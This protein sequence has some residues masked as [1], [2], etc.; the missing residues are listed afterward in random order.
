MD[1]NEH[2]VAKEWA[3]PAFHVWS[4]PEGSVS[5]WMWILISVFSSG[6]QNI[7]L[8]G[9][10]WS[11]PHGP[12]DFDLGCASGWDTW[13]CLGLIFCPLGTLLLPEYHSGELSEKWGTHQ[14]FGNDG[15][16]CDVGLGGKLVCGLLWFH[17]FIRMW[18][19]SLRRWSETT[20]LLLF[21]FLFTSENSSSMLN[22]I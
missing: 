13:V 5:F 9:G 1:R 14:C 3:H 16:V 21:F 12:R 11:A 18:F 10:G 2:S 4:L 20:F 8:W 19:R 6:Q 22:L 17:Y 7:G 15:S